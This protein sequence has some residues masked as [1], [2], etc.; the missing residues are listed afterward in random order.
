MTRWL[1]VAAL[2]LASLVVGGLAQGHPGDAMFED[3]KA[4]V[5]LGPRK[6]GSDGGLRGEQWVQARLEAMGL[7]AERFVVGHRQTP[8]IA[9]FGR[10]FLP[11]R[12]VNVPDATLLVTLPATAPADPDDGDA[13][14]L[15]AHYDTV[16]GSPGAI[17]N[18]S[19]VSVGLELLRR[20]ADAHRPRDVMVAFTA[21]EE[22]RLAGAHA[23]ADGLEA[24]GRMP[25]LALSLDLVGLRD[26]TLTLN[27]LSRKLGAPWLSIVHDA[28]DAAGVHLDGPLP[29]QVVSRLLPE[30]E[31]SDHGVFSMRGVPAFHVYHRP[32]GRLYLDYHRETDTMDQVD[33]ARLAEVADFV[34]ALATVPERFPD[35]P[36]AG[37]VWWVGMVWPKWL[38][39]GLELGLL[40]L[41][42]LA[43]VRRP[44]TS[45]TER[46]LGIW[47][48]G[49]VLVLA[50]AAT[51]GVEVIVDEA[52][53]HP[54]P[55]AHAPAKV[56]LH[57]VLV[58][59][60]VA[61]GLLA[62][63]WLA[64]HPIGSDGRRTLVGAV[65]CAVL[66][67]A[68]LGVG[69]FELAWLPLLAGAGLALTLRPQT[70]WVVMG[71]IA[72]ALPPALALAPG[73]VREA[74]YN[75]FLPPET[76]ITILLAIVTFPL[77][78]AAFDLAGRPWPARAKRIATA[79]LLA[80]VVA[81]GALA[82]RSPPC[83]VEQF[84][85]DGL[86]CERAAR[87]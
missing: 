51:F 73:M 40:G 77:G 35:G 75:G 68:L 28:A 56:M 55:W 52:L 78:L 21:C 2:V 36:G 17:D 82:T 59:A 79:S 57:L 43:F 49:L 50:W 10:Q 7:S 42:G 14:L 32:P 44:E 12:T 54:A 63:P 29:H 38:V 5:E 62:I 70:L 18:A 48:S 61:R 6:A 45:P 22:T 33:P 34:T 87:M 13:F 30:I 16:A 24:S 80:L 47:I 65:M 23:L 64:R 74:T 27:G 39:I 72:A 19:A 86:A 46:P 4:L 53:G 85:R 1:V 9:V 76:P 58:A 84:E 71:W 66:G 25:A 37:A 41:V 8:A 15:L 81:T 69:V 11:P 83:P 3:A 31:R 20:L 60:V 67:V 26:G